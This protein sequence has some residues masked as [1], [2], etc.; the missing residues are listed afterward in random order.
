MNYL[1]TV[2]QVRGESISGETPRPIS[3]FQKGG[4]NLPM[5]YFVEA[6]ERRESQLEL[7]NTQRR[8]GQSRKDVK[9]TRKTQAL[10]MTKR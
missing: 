6:T 10:K 9:Y 1:R 8:L 4:L 2:L 3:V 5:R 7:G